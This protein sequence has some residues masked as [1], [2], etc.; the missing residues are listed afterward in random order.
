MKRQHHEAHLRFVRQLT[1]LLCGDNTSTEAAHVRYSELRAG[2]RPVSINEKADDNWTIPLCGRC[3]R[4]QHGNG[5]RGFWTD[6]KVDP[7]YVA[8]ALWAAT[9]DVERGERLLTMHRPSL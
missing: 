5:E 6:K 2:K 3:H 7:V 9:G 4:D 1:C 8:M